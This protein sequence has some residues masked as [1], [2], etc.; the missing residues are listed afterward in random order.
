MNKELI[1]KILPHVVAVVLF[2]LI[3]SIYSK[4]LLEGKKLSTHDYNV[5]MSVA[6]ANNDYQKAND[7]LVFWNNSL[8]S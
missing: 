2:L 1:K 7:R 3:A 4:P 8:F 6:K 5:Y